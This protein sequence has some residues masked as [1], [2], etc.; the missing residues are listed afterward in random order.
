MNEEKVNTG[1]RCNELQQ[2]LCHPAH[3]DEQQQQQQQ[4]SNN[5]STATHRA[6]TAEIHGRCIQIHTRTSYSIVQLSSIVT[7]YQVQVLLV[8]NTH[9]VPNKSVWKKKR[10]YVQR[11]RR[12]GRRD[13]APRLSVFWGCAFYFWITRSL[14]RNISDWYL[15][16]RTNRHVGNFDE[17]TRTQHPSQGDDAS[18]GGVAPGRFGRDEHGKAR[19]ANTTP[20]GGP[21]LELERLRLKTWSK[22]DF[23]I[24]ETTW[25]T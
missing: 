2:Q 16:I 13:F 12:K 11:K 19:R 3:D 4:Y 14:T 15:P 1:I 21:H 24:A 20:N 6:V 9:T 7:I 25:P 8:W 17:K 18:T 10:T 5:S 23:S 22:S